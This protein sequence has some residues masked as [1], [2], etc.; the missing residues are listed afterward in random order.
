MKDLERHHHPTGALP[1]GQLM[2]W[3]TDCHECGGSEITASARY[4]CQDDEVEEV[5]STCVSTGPFD[6][7]EDI[8]ELAY[9]AMVRGYR[10][11]AVPGQR[12]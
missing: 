2:L 12:R 11:L 3:I 10:S 9:D 1:I 8:L 7:I 5:W 6:S 4:Q